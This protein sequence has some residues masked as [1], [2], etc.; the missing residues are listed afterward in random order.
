MTTTA[1]RTPR[2]PQVPARTWFGLVGMPGGGWPG[3]NTPSSYYNGNTYFGY[4]DGDGNIRVASYNHATGAVVI[5]PAIVTGLAVDYHS[6]PSVLVRSSDHKI[7]VSIAPHN[8]LHMYVAVSSNAEDVSA[9]GAATDIAGTLGGTAF[10]YANLFQLSGESGKIYLYF[11]DQV[12]GTN[13]LCFSTSTNGGSTWTALTILYA[14]TGKSSYWVIDSDSTNRIDIVTS[15]AVADADG[16]GD[17][18]HFYYTGGSYFKSDGTLISAGLPLAPSNLTKIYN[19]ATNGFIRD[20][21]GIISS[22][23]PYAVWASYNSAGA[24]SNENYWYGVLSGG[25]WTVN[26]ID[27]DGSLPEN[28]GA[29]E[30]G[31]SIDATDPNTVFASKKI[32]GRWQMHRYVTANGGSTWTATRLTFDTPDGGDLKPSTPRNAAVGLRC[33]WLS[34]TY[35]PAGSPFSFKIRGYPNPERLW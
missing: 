29:L 25:T 23:G 13:K 31:C 14:N 7:L 26:K 9:F 11:R 16:S 30:G 22:G 5:S 24:G 8:T 1:L 34:G 3:Q 21:L 33:L 20:P 35:G 2:Q 15:D 19:G 32:S 17:L 10:T 27:D 4:Q 28:P 12:S 18:Y 6:A